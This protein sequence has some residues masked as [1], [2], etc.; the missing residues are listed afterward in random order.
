MGAAIVNVESTE[1]LKS[2]NRLVEEI[3]TQHQ[4]IAAFCPD[5]VKCD[6]SVHFLNVHND[7]HIVTT[8]G[9]FSR[10]VVVDNVIVGGGTSVIIDPAIGIIISD[11]LTRDH[12]S[13]G[14]HPD[15]GKTFKGFLYP[16][17]KKMRAT[18]TEM[19]RMIPHL[20]HISWDIAVSDKEEIILIE[21]NVNN[22]FVSLSTVS[23]RCWQTLS[24]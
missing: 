10:V 19:A 22:P 20:R 11:G 8:G 17:W 24:L 15:S 18:V 9:R 5:T 4:D 14:K 2:R 13:I 21:I 6:S 1:S 23:R 12:E 7:V 3:V 16:Y